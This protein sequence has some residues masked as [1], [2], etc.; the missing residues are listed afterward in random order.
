MEHMLLVVDTYYTDNT[1][2][3]LDVVVVVVVVVDVDAVLLG[4][5]TEEKND[6]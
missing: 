6:T 1:A 3:A 5:D 2:C 4:D